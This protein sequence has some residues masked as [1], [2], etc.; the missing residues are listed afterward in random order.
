MLER[1]I[2]LDYETRSEVD[3]ESA[4]AINY[5]QHSSTSI[6]CVGYR[7]DE[8][9]LQLWIP[10]RASIPA[11][12]LHIF[13]HGTLVAHNASFERAITRFVLPRYSTLTPNQKALIESLPASRWRCTAAKAAACSLP[14]SLEGAA[15]ALQ[16]PTQKDMSG[17]RILKKY[18]KPR[19]PTKSNPK[20]WCDDKE[21][22]RAIYRYCLTDVQ[23]GWELDRAL[24]DLSLQEQRVWE[25]DQKINDRGVLIDIP[26]VKVILRMIKRETTNIALGVQKLSQGTIGSVTQTAKVLAWVNARGAD[27]PN[28]QAQ[29]IEY[30][31]LEKDLASGIRT[32]LEYRQGGSRSSTAKYLG[33]L[34][35]VGSDNRA[36]EL[37]LFN[38]ATPTARWAGKRI[39]L[40]NLPRPTLKNFDSD[41]AIQ[42]LRLRGRAGI[43]NEY[44]DSNVMKVLVSAIRGM[45]IAS[46]GCKFYC[47]DWSAIEARL[48]F[49]VAGHHQGLEAYRQKRK[50]YEEMAS[51]TFG[52]PLDEVEKDSLER[53]VA[54]ESVL[55]C[56]YGMGPLK[57][58]MQCHRKGISQVTD[59]I[60]KKAVY[61]Y[62]KV[63]WPIP[64]M[65]K[66]LEQ[67]T[68]KAI[69]YPGK[70]YLLHKVAIYVKEDFLH[71]K[72]PSGRRLRYYKPR[73][74]F[75]QLVSG[76][77]VT[78]IRHWAS[79]H[80]L[81]IEQVIWGGTL[82]NHIVQGIARDL[83]VHGLFNVENAGY[84]VQ[85]HT[86]DEILAEKENGNLEEY[87][88]LM[89]SLPD[90]AEGL[91][92]EA[93]CWSGKRFRK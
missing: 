46:P 53:F 79:I 18:H 42:L 41:R 27:M 80:K 63:H 2:I 83:L 35:A 56:Q 68:V 50:L 4:G 36:R 30:K 12:L 87:K 61:T 38:G 75:K 22:L 34:S 26:T 14:R 37:F 91:P 57:F 45:I 11:D 44:G 78:E 28:L 52:I 49:W 10:E 86:H 48:A 60:A 66:N 84:R 81:W 1:S 70:V 40:H 29:T 88:R 76:S 65:W 72:L 20:L 32:M 6:L 25:L 62:R 77:L 3:L 58:K 19:K 93:E 90:W 55:G 43:A 8:G 89:L 15:A 31:L 9:E 69:R 85:T 73:V 23:S 13:H 21:E 92:M 39:Q 59:E 51:A 16:L 17:N 7:V 24:P 74:C 67:A 64:A 71:I 33:M 54:K 47:G 82:T 5:A